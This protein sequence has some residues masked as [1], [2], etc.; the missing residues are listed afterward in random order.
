MKRPAAIFAFLVAAGSLCAQEPTKEKFLPWGAPVGDFTLQDR[1]GQK[2]GPRDLRGSIWVAHFF[3]P[4]CTGACTKSTPNM[5]KLQDAYRGKSNV[6]FVS[7]ALHGDTLD[8]LNGYAET[9]NAEPGQ[10][11][12]LT[13]SNEDHVHNII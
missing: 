7:I 3:F 5:K 8:T 9:Q 10:W 4:Q 1:T 13:D 12:F 11:Y 6:K 2:I